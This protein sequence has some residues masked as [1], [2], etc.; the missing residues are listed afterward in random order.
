LELNK[1]ITGEDH[2]VVF[3]NFSLRLFHYDSRNKIVNKFMIDHPIFIADFKNRLDRAIK[4]GGFVV[5]FVLFLD[6]Q[7]KLCFAYFNSSITNREVYRYGMDGTFLDVIRFKEE[8]DPL[9]C[10]DRQGNFYVSLGLNTR[11][12]IFRIEK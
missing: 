12:G 4:D 6:H 9:Y 7:S 10:A 11:I 8:V 2:L 5:P 3:S 1:L